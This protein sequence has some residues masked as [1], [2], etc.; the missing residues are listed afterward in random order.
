MGDETAMQKDEHFALWFCAFAAS[1]ESDVKGFGADPRT[2]TFA[3]MIFPQ[4]WDWHLQW[5]ERRCCL[6]I[7]LKGHRVA[8][9]D[10]PISRASLR[11]RRF[12]FG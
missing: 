1:P 7:I 9:P 8:A 4:A 3:M 2:F 6:G 12:V 10:A 11:S 5:R